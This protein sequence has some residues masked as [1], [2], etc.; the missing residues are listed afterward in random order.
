[1][2]FR[3]V[4][5]TTADPVEAPAATEEA[6]SCYICANA[7]CEDD[8]CCRA[9]THLACCTQAICCACLRKSCYRCA[10]REDCDAVVSF[11]PFCR[12]NRPVEALD[13]FLSGEGPCATCV[14]GDDK[15]AAE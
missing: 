10:C 2:D 7:F 12:S 14:K 6:V 3:R 4:L 9:V 15:P 13:L 8:E 1:M 11:C 5:T